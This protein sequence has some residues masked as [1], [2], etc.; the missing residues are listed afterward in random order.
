MIT[1][2]LKDQTL[3]IHVSDKFTID[4]FADFQAAYTENEFKDIVIDF[5]ETSHIDSGG[6]GMLLQLRTH[7]GED[8][9]R[10]TLCGL[11]DHILK[12]FEVVNFEK[13]F[14]MA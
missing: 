5:S 7:L 3:W 4:S 12:V 8:S 10:I 2:K 6:L 13:L 9:N 1:Y 14:K 11:S